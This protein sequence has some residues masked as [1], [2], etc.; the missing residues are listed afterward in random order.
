MEHPWL[1]CIRHAA[2]KAVLGVELQDGPARSVSIC[3][4]R[5]RALCWRRIIGSDQ[6]GCPTRS[7]AL[8]WLFG[9]LREKV[10]TRHL[11]PRGLCAPECLFACAIVF[12]V[13]L[14]VIP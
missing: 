13:D 9:Q 1:N 8:A 5:R 3:L 10:L 2:G 6:R 4:R 11:D 12:P 7:L 14:R